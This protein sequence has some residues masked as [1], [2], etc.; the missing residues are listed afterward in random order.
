MFLNQ[1]NFSHD[2]LTFYDGDSS[3]DPIIGRYCGQTMQHSVVESPNR[4]VFIHFQ[5][6]GFGSFAGFK[7]EYQPYS[8]K[9]LY[10]FSKLLE[11]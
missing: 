10:K 4:Q 1:F 3:V 8:K 6:D 5:S 7:L 2:S 9:F 11:T